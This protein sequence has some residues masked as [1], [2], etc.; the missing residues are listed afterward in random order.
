MSEPILGRHSGLAGRAAH[1]GCGI[2][3]RCS[4]PT[5]SQRSCPLRSACSRI[6]GPANRTVTASASSYPVPVRPA[7]AA[8]RPPRAPAMSIGTPRI[9]RRRS[10]LVRA[11]PAGT[12]NRPVRFRTLPVSCRSWRLST[13]TT[14]GSRSTFGMLCPGMRG[15]LCS[16]GTILYWRSCI[17]TT[18]LGC[19]RRVAC[20]CVSSGRG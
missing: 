6:G 10:M 2:R 7:K 9:T 1:G 3:R 11:L 14:C 19:R 5:Q 12:G 20:P 15:C 18:L 8:T 13:L 17:P 16:I 4:S